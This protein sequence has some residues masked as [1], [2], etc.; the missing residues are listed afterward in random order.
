MKFDLYRLESIILIIIITG[1]HK[2]RDLIPD[3][4]KIPN[5]KSRLYK[6][7]KLPGMDRDFEYRLKFHANN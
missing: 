6:L 5:L 7:I 2:L 4:L 3:I 1:R